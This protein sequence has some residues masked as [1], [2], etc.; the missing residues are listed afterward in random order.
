MMIGVK[1]TNYGEAT[2]FETDFSNYTLYAMT[3][4]VSTYTSGTLAQISKFPEI[5]ISDIAISGSIDI[6][7]FRDTTN[8]SGL[9]A[10]ADPV[11]TGVT[12]KYNDSHVQFNK[13]G[14]RQE[15]V[16]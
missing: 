12:V 16:L 2:V 7:L 3:T 13:V 8:V 10:G 4:N 15:F 11:G 14:S 5:D 1:K 9:F 6:V